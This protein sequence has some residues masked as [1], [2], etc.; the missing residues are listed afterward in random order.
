LKYP[1]TN[2]NNTKPTNPYKIDIYDVYWFFSIILT[3]SSDVHVVVWIKCG[4]PTDC[5]CCLV[6]VK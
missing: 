3:I 5:S 6:S 2:E 1:F 4:L